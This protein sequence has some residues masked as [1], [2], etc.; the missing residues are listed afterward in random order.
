M[1][2][3]VALHSNIKI[4]TILLPGGQTL[5]ILDANAFPLHAPL[6][7]QKYSEHLTRQTDIFIY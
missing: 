6:T 7:D 2:F 4:G 5:N 1:T 3:P